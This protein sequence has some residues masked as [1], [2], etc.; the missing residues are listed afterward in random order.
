MAVT[1]D[2]VREIAYT[3]GDVEEGT[4]YGTPAFRAR[5]VLFVRLREDSE[6][7][8]VRMDHERRAEMMAAD[9]ETYFITDHCLNYPWILVSLARIK[10][11]ALRDLLA[12]SWQLA[13]AQRALKPSKAKRTTPGRRTRSQ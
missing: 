13:T 12:M 9:P 8:V 3:L 7:L 2:T 5:G 6:T 1:F 4:S 11:D 10:I